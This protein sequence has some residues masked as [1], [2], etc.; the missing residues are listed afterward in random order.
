MILNIK[1]CLENSGVE[2]LECGYINQIN[3]S[4]SGR[5]C[6]DSEIAIEKSVLNQGKQADVTYLAMI[7]YGTYDLDHLQNRSV[8][9]IDGIRFAFHKEHWKEAISEAKKIISKGYELFI[10]PMVS[11]RY[12]DD[13]FKEL[14]EL[15][16]KELPG[17]KAF[18]V[19]DSF[20][21]MD[22]MTLKHKLDLADT[23]LN[24]NMKLGFHAHNNRQMAFSN[25]CFLLNYHSRHRLMLDSSIFG[26][27]KG[28]GNLCTELIMP[29]LN[30]LGNSYSTVHIY[31][32]IESF[33]SKVI[34]TH[35]WGYCLDYYLSSLYGVT[36]SYIKIFKKDE[37]V[38]TDILIKLLSSIPEEK[39]A[40]C[41]KIFASSHLKNILGS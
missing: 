32:M 12:S 3:G 10:Q 15:C 25:A 22:S 20:G 16:N 29:Q 27:G 13:E 19:V 30:A 23:Y 24:K 37:R 14:I 33:F 11:L 7:D 38:T 4:N 8:L 36:P 31:E 1:D 9:G 6:F 41:D 39:K 26:M 35:P 17:A 21:Q 34:K 40:A 28:A 5:T 2:Y 18:Y